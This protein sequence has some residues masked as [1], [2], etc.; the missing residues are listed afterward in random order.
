MNNPSAMLFLCVANSARSQMAEGMARYI[1]PKGVT[2]YSAGSEPSQ[3]NPMAIRAMKEL[4]I[5][6]SGHRAKAIKEIPLD[7]V[8]VVITLCEDEV[9]PTIAGAVKRLH[10]PFP[11]P[12]AAEGSADDVLA[13]FRRVRDELRE[14]VSGLF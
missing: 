2:I 12:A 4:G 8:D 3:L 14:R 10:W 1:A 13:A 7:T 11:D 9:C 6:I 5:D